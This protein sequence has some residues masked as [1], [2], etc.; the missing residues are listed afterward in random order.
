MKK[1]FLTVSVLLLL[2][3]LALMGY[4][5]YQKEVAEKSARDYETFVNETIGKHGETGVVA[6]AILGK[7]E[8]LQE[9]G[10]QAEALQENRKLL[11][12][13]LD[14]QINREAIWRMV[15]FYSAPEEKEKLIE[16]LIGVYRSSKDHRT[17]LEAVYSII[18]IHQNN[19]E[20]DKALEIWDKVEK[21][22]L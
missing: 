5:I 11:Q 16:E 21:M 22:S 19:G 9:L 13:D 8:T 12:L 1:L 14:C 2:V 4:R 10:R 18:S 3:L 17:R 6:L 15:D 7:V 20:H